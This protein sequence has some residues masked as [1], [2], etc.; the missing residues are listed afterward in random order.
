ME[1]N[2]GTKK[3]N[4]LVK[5]VGL[6]MIIL[7]LSSGVAFML[8]LNNGAGDDLIN[9]T[10][11]TLGNDLDD[12]GWM[13]FI[14]SGCGACEVQ[15]QILGSEITGLKVIDCGAS[16]EDGITCAQNNIKVIP[17]WHNVFSNETIAGVQQITQLEEMSK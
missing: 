4:G 2:K 1:N 12:A 7:L 10:K 5:A 9:D 11:R 13:L 3:K 17:T 8:N 16:R 6:G 14:Q 15:K